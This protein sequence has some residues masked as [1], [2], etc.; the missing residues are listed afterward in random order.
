MK[1]KQ[2]KTIKATQLGKVHDDFAVFFKQTALER[3]GE[4]VAHHIIGTSVLDAD[5]TRINS[6]FDEEVTNTYVSSAIVNGLPFFS[7]DYC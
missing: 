2:N 4:E 6:V 3:L 7:Q 5:F 1:P